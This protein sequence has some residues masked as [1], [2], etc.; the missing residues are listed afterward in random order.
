MKR[1]ISFFMVLIL[2]P[3]VGFTDLGQDSEIH[4]KVIQLDLFSYNIKDMVLRNTEEGLSVEFDWIFDVAE[5]ALPNLDETIITLSFW[6]IKETPVEDGN[7]LVDIGRFRT[8]FTLSGNSV[9]I[10]G[11]KLS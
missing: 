4:N 1:S 7:P 11:K 6:G 9:A 3:L 10:S 8:S 2:L 5:G